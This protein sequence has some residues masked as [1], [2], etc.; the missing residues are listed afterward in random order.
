[1]LSIDMVLL[2]LILILI[3]TWIGYPVIVQLVAGVNKNACGV[4]AGGRQRPVAVVLAAYNEELCLGERLSNLLHLDYP[5]ELITV[6][7]GLDGCDDDSV[8]IVKDAAEGVERVRVYDFSERRGKVAVL[9][10]LVKR[11]AED[12]ED[13]G[14]LVFTDA[15]SMFRADALNRMLPHFADDKVGGV[16]GRLVFLSTE[17]RVKDVEK[18]SATAE[19]S[20]WGWETKLKMA[21]SA[22]DS[23]LGANGAIYAMRAELFWGEISDNCLID[24]FIIGMKIREQGKR[25]IYEPL[26][27]AE[28]LLPEQKAEWGRRVRIGAGG[29]QALGMCSSCLLPK[30]GKFA[31]MFWSHKVLRWFSPHVLVILLFLLFYLLASFGGVMRCW[32]LLGFGLFVVIVIAAIYLAKNTWLGRLKVMKV[33]LLLEHFIVMQAALLVGFVRYCRGGLKGYWVR[34][35]RR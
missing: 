29:Y 21:E 26:A 10:D 31:W 12:M 11:A 18:E 22:V 1:M 35:P 8:R 15:N 24:D 5:A 32:G 30:Y 28:E 6:Y 27:I 17:S 25:L 23:C 14:I 4:S 3:Y 19:S 7:V 33:L 9:K 20:Y 34:T 2:I 13:G 16:C